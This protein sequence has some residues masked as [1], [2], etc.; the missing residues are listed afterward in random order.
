MKETESGGVTR[1][2]YRKDQHHVDAYHLFQR[3]KELEETIRKGREAMSH[4]I[5]A[6]TPSC[7]MG[8]PVCRPLEAWLRQK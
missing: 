2:D 7:H 4:S 3:V 1:Q 8:C 5:E 6:H